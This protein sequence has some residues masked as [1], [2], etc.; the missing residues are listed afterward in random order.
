[1]ADDSRLQ[2]TRRQL[3]LGA[4]AAAAGSAGCGSNGNSTDPTETSDPATTTGNVSITTP[5]PTTGPSTATNSRTGT[6]TTTEPPTETR[7]QPTEGTETPRPTDT[8]TATETETPTDTE[9]PIPETGTINAVLEGEN[10]WPNNFFTGE[11]DLDVPYTAEQLRDRYHYQQIERIADSPW[12]EG[13]ENKQVLREFPTKLTD[14]QWREEKVY[15]PLEKEYEEEVEDFFDPEAYTGDGNLKER[16]TESEYPGFWRLMELLTRDGVSSNHDFIRTA[17]LSMA[18][19]QSAGKDTY[20]IDFK[21]LSGFHGL[22]IAITNPTYDANDKDQQRTWGIET[23]PGEDEPLWEDTETYPND[24][25][26]I[27]TETN[28]TEDGIIPWRNLGFMR[29]T[30]ENRDDPWNVNLEFHDVDRWE[31][32]VRNPREQRGM[33]YVDSACLAGY[34]NEEATSF[35]EL[36]EFEGATLHVYP[37]KIEYQLN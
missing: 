17:A 6:T 32:F 36:P 3:V 28:A 2:L 12:I 7:T 37:D 24:E 35:G 34:I 13:Q 18:E 15:Q 9:T 23:D 21:T 29:E 25:G 8:D 1:M 20:T 10:P 16:N 26:R 11:Y 27:F 33:K 14:S 19:K 22:G 4:G 5:E 31:E 30:E